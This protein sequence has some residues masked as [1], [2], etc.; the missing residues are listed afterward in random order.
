MKTELT[1]EQSAHLIELG[2]SA[3]KAS[4][5]C[6]D[7]NGT[8]AYVSG[9]EANTVRDCVNGQ[10]YVEESK[11]FTLANVMELLPKE[12]CSVEREISY[13]LSMVTSTFNSSASYSH[14]CYTKG[15]GP[16][17]IATELIDALYELLI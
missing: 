9:E 7:F 2:V 4:A 16:T 3:D 17:K 14:T 1:R 12:I 6:L 15:F 11:V 10:F 13:Y 8:C 5:T